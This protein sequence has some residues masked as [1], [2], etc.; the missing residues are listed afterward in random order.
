[1]WSNVFNEDDP[2]NPRLA[3]EYG[4]HY[5]HIASGAYG[6]FP[7]GLGSPLYENAAALELCDAS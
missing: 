3:E 2:E 4:N 5:G 6:L 1:M 7:A